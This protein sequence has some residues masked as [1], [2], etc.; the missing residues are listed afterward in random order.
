MNRKVEIKRVTKET[1]ISLSI[2]LDGQGLSSI[3]SGIG[4]FDH[5]LTAFCLHGGFDMELRCKGDLLVDCHHSVEDV[6]IVLGRAVAQAL[7]DKKGIKRYG[8]FSLPMD[9]ALAV[10]NL[11]ISNRPY[12]VFNADFKGYKIGDLNVQMIREF[13]YAFAINAGITL[14]I[15]LIYGSN[16][17][18][19]AEAIFKA[20]AHALKLGVE[21]SGIDKV[22]STKGSL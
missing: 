10:C 4:F 21:R 15:N 13:F 8:N 6:G 17:H 22:L 2:D 7:A 19:I 11:D 5:M 20:F 18:H 16:D 9:E 3:D 12:L 1:E 14:H